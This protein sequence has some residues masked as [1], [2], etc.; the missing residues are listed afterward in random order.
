MEAAIEE[1]KKLKQYLNDCFEAMEYAES[2]GSY[3]DHDTLDEYKAER[4][5]QALMVISVTG[6]SAEKA[7]RNS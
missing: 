3:W 7:F 1:L 2:T 4:I 6:W 5:A